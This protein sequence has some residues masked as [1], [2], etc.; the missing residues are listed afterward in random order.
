MEYLGIA[1]QELGMQRCQVVVICY[2][3]VI[4]ETSF[5]N[6]ISNKYSVMSN[7]GVYPTGHKKPAIYTERNVEAARFINDC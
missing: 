5:Y 4:A 7:I 6:N 1:R 3:A 2:L